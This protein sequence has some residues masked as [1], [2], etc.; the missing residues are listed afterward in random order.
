LFAGV[1]ARKTHRN[2]LD[3]NGRGRDFH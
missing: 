2:A 3:G 1:F